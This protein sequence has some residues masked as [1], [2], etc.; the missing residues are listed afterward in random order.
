[1]DLSEMFQFDEVKV[2]EDEH[3]VIID[4]HNIAYITAYSTISKDYSDNGVF[5]L[6]RSNFLSKLFSD[7]CAISP[8]KVILAFD[9]KNSWRYSIYGE[10]KA[11]R[12]K[13]YGRYPLDKDAFNIA[14]SA[15]ILDIKR[16]FPAIYTIK[17]DNAEGDDII[18]VLCKYVF[19]KQ[20]YNVT[21]V[22]GDTDL[23]QLITNNITQYNPNKNKYFN[24][25]NPK[26]DLDVKILSGDSSDN[27]PPIKRL[28]GPK[29][30]E[31]ILSMGIES[32]IQSHTTQLEIDT[33]NESFKR[34]TQLI[35]LNFIP[36][37]IRTAIIKEYET[38]PYTPIDGKMVVKYLMSNRLHKVRNNW[39][40]IS[41][42]LYNIN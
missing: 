31:K 34:N 14:L 23:N 33:I 8:T 39:Q 26:K 4:G 40:N 16:I 32:F 18:G 10:Y 6:W 7:I 28:V 20:N 9:S 5:E 22:S 19:N 11:H 2:V 41:K 38:Y 17:V 30:A 36:L 15:M 1:M 35:D 3:V 24:I 27:I 25:L 21:I 12:K 42:V 29:K 13:Q 37:N